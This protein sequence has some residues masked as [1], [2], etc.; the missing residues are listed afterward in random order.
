VSRR[1]SGR[2]RKSHIPSRRTLTVVTGAAG[3]VVAVTT[4]AGP[5]P[6]VSPGEAHESDA[7]A[8]P[9]TL[10]VDSKSP[11]GA[12]Q[13]E[14]GHRS[15]SGSGTGAVPGISQAPTSKPWPSP[16]ASA[17]TAQ[18]GRGRG[19]SASPSP[20]DG[21]PALPVPLPSTT[22]SFPSLPNLPLGGL[23]VS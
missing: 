5:L 15:G 13:D 22:S 18:P 6:L 20:S 4:G 21:A 1:S 8:E 11:S 16:H 19:P 9:I 23:G 10:Y 7:R 14:T 2:H 3:V 17:P 12:P